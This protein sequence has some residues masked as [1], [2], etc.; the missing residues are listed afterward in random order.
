MLANATAGN[1]EFKIISPTN[2]ATITV[3]GGGGLG[4]YGSSGDVVD[5]RADIKDFDTSS[6]RNKV[7]YHIKV[8]SGTLYV[9]GIYG[10][11]V[12]V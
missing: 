11:Y 2:S 1:G 7:D 3:T 10:W 12:Y 4:V 6:S 8:A 5:M 9:Y